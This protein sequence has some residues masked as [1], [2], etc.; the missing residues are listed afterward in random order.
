MFAIMSPPGVSDQLA[1]M[2]TGDIH[3]PTF[4]VVVATTDVEIGKT[5]WLCVSFRCCFCFGL[6]NQI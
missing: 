4:A 2:L 3:C 1:T 6:Q 5:L